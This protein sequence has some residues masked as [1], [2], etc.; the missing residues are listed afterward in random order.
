[1]IVKQKNP[2]LEP[3][4][5]VLIVPALPALPHFFDISVGQAQF[6]VTS[7]LIG[8]GVGQLADEV[9][10]ISPRHM[11]ALLEAGFK[12]EDI[13]YEVCEVDPPCWLSILAS[14][15]NCSTHC[16]KIS[17]GIFCEVN[18]LG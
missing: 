9:S 3:F 7:Y 8:Y 17:V 16:E 1:M 15:N 12:S 11:D 18:R 6:S 14:S 5:A 13:Q 2:I 10:G 4:G